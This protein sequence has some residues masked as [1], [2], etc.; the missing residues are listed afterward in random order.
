MAEQAGIGLSEIR[1]DGGPTRNHLLMQFQSD[2]L[3]APILVSDIEEASALGA[4]LAGGL[5]TGVWKSIAQLEQ[6]YS[7]R[8]SIK[9]RMSVEDRK[10]RYEG[11]KRAVE[12][13]RGRNVSFI[14]KSLT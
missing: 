5:G 10:Q 14:Q 3:N 6:M 2:M 11:W 13:A 4:A 8:D 7:S 1:V 9:P 12:L